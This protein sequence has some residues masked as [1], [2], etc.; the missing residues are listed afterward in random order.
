[1]KGGNKHEA[2]DTKN[3]VLRNHPNNRKKKHGKTRCALIP[4]HS[5][6]FNFAGGITQEFSENINAL[7]VVTLIDKVDGEEGISQ[8]WKAVQLGRPH[9][10]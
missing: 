3:S 7:E 1:V 2:P 5:L 10:I 8:G 9:L 6:A 4:P